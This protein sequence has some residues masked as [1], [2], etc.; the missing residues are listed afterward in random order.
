M[1]GVLKPSISL[2]PPR[3]GLDGWLSG[4]ALAL[5]A[6]G[7]VMVA[8]ASVAVAEKSTGTP[9]YYFYKQFSYALLGLLLGA[10]TFSVRMKAWEQSGFWLLAFAFFLL[11]IVLIPGIGLKINSARRWLDFGAFRLQASEPARLALII[12]MVGF[13]VRRQAELQN[14]FK[15]VL[16]SLVP[17]VLAS[18]LLMAEPDFGATALLLMVTFLLL[19]M[20]G[21]RLLHLGALAFAAVGALALLV[22][23][24]PYRLRRVM[25]F[26]DPWSDIENSGWQLAQ[27]LIAIGR[28][29]WTG[30]GLGNSLQKLLYLPET[31]TDFIFAIWAEEFGLVGIVVL[32]ALFGIVVWRAFAIGRAAQ[33]RR[34]FFSAYLCYAMGAWMGAQVLI[35]MAVNM[36]LVPTKGLTLP[37]ISYG[38]SS[39]VT[40]CLMIALVLRADH[41]NRVERAGAPAGGFRERVL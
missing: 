8:S 35:N 13:V 27:S 10:M 40:V 21:A 12:Y 16:W 37:M 5:L 4:T 38:G 28:G 22:V 19:F 39:L 30:V 20:A 3:Y 9:L 6:I 34:H 11:T 17:V 2:P 29:E 33:Q 41:E 25:N 26:T 18:A 24:A 36:G 32:L 15:Q 23:A 14:S 7:L 1:I 31:H